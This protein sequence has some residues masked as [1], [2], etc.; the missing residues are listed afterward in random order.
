MS[1]SLDFLKNFTTPLRKNDTARKEIVSKDMNIF[2]W[3]EKNLDFFK[4][5]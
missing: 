4:C 2:E 5:R 1:H 3:I